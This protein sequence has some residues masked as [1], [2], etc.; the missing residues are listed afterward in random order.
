MIKTFYEEVYR[1]QVANPAALSAGTLPASY[2]NVS[3]FDRFAF[4]LE[5]GATDQAVDFKVVQATAAAGTG[6]KDVSGAAITQF[7]T[8]DDNKQAMIEVEVRKLDIN[9]G[10]YF[11]AVTSA[12]TGGTAT[13]ASIVFYGVNNGVVPVTQPAAF[14]QRVLVAG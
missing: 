10:F 7:A 13:T 4:V 5:L 8:T 3:D 14:A 9:N 1:Q 11:V 2:I 12:L 6:S